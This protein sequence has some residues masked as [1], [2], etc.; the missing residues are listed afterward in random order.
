MAAEYRKFLYLTQVAGHPVTPAKA[1]DEAWHLHL[2]YTR[3]YWEGFCGEVLTKPLH[4]EPG[5]GKPG[6]IA[7]FAA[8]FQRTQE[9]YRRIFGTEP[10]MRVWGTAKPKASAAPK[11]R[12]LGWLATGLGSTALAGGSGGDVVLILVGIGL[13]G[14]VLFAVA[15][16]GQRYRGQGSSTSDAGA[17]CGGFFVVTETV[18]SSH[19]HDAGA[20]C[21]TDSSGSSCGSSCG[22]G[23][24]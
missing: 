9:S 2:L 3:S 22:G 17:S 5:T 8:Q 4:H 11:K 24:D 21:G 6:D 16:S 13:L 10:P 18:E 15:R 19:G 14:M 20:S 12:V 1:I 23:G 7:H